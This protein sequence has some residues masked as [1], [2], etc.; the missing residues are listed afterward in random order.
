MNEDNQDVSANM[1]KVEQDKYIKDMED[2]E[3]ESSIVAAL[4]SV[5]V[6]T[7]TCIF[8]LFSVNKMKRHFTLTEYKFLGPKAYRES[9]M[10]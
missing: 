2:Y 10:I 8:C 1:L 6:V 7:I 5:T 9:E 4:L 3:I